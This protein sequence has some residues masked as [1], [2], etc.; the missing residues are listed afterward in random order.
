MPE[1]RP[2]EYGELY[3]DV[4]D[5]WYPGADS[6]DDA[7]AALTELAGGGPVLE[8]GAGTGRL[9]IPLAQRVP[10]VWALDNSPRML[11]RLR[12]KPGSSAIRIVEADM[13]RF[14]LPSD[15]PSFALAF[16]AF[17]TLFLL[18]GRA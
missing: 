2:E 18:R 6:T 10:E 16:A 4:Y 13:A 17:N 14:D 3:A 15:A 7:V 1:P 5:E 9:S 12:A 11:A 8:L